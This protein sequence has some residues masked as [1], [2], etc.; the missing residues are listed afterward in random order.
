ME[1]QDIQL[2]QDYIC[3]LTVSC[4]QSVNLAVKHC[5]VESCRANMRFPTSKLPLTSLGFV[6]KV[7]N[8][9]DFMY[10]LANGVL[11]CR[12]PRQQARVPIDVMK[13]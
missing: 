9:L 4:Y 10:G 5:G 7:V 1:Y 13:H 8:V 6:F 12:R 3:T 11:P 2:A